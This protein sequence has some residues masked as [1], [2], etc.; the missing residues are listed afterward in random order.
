M[1]ATDAMS[2]LW[3]HNAFDAGAGIST[4]TMASCAEDFRGKE[5]RVRPGFLRPR[6][7]ARSSGRG[8]RSGALTPLD[9]AVSKSR[10]GRGAATLSLN[11]CQALMSPS[12][13]GAIP[14]RPESR[15]RAGTRP[16]ARLAFRCAQSSIR[17]MTGPE[18][19]R[20]PHVTF[21]ANGV[22]RRL[23][24]RNRFELRQPLTHLFYRKLRA[25]ALQLE[26]EEIR[27]GHPRSR[28]APFQSPV[29]PVRDV[30]DLDHFRHVITMM[31]YRQLSSRSRATKLLAQE[32]APRNE[33]RSA[34]TL[35][36]EW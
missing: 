36:S 12:A 35:R 30:A 5:F 11:A 24:R 32:G 19:G 6:A 15:C 14:G 18:M 31:A 34:N 17:T 9:V 7:L 4:C 8:F 20:S 13:A 1:G 33:D 23:I 25:H 29:Q 28:R 27:Q 22:D 26:A 16:R 21:G 3:V 10:A 2:E